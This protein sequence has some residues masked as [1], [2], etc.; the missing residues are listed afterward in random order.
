M[1]C[2][3]QHERRKQGR[4][5]DVKAANNVVV[6]AAVVV[7]YFSLLIPLDFGGKKEKESR[8]SRLG[9]IDQKFVMMTNRVGGCD[10]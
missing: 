1:T 9:F 3:H 7:S 4:E 2:H 5:N 10:R 6:V 8:N